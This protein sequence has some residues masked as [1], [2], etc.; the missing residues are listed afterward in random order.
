[1]Q[2]VYEQIWENPRYLVSSGDTPSILKEG[3]R[4]NAL[5]IAAMHKHAK[6]AKLILQTIEQPQF[7]EHLHGCKN[8]TTAEVSGNLCALN[9]LI[10]STVFTCRKLV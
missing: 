3:T 6:M 9:G 10:K 2:N 7:I 8:D 1:M 5:H 4:Y